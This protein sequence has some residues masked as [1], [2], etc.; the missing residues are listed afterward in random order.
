M[1]IE[2]QE[3]IAR[4]ARRYEVIQLEEVE[5]ERRMRQEKTNAKEYSQNFSDGKM[6]VQEQLLRCV[7]LVRV[8]V[9]EEAERKERIETEKQERKEEEK[10]QQV[11]S[12]LDRMITRDMEEQ[13]RHRR[14]AEEM[15]L[16]FNEAIESE[17]SRRKSFL[18]EEEER[19]RRMVE[20]KHR[21]H[22]NSLMK[23]LSAH[24]NARVANKLGKKASE[25]KITEDAVKNMMDDTTY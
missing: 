20:D 15:K 5:R 7:D 8:D 4:E 25:R 2:Y 23:E 18:L 11:E 17:L 6:A 1:A 16:Q 22:V 19:Q 13:E 21:P 14:I 10:I 3:Q 12:K 24:I 9:L